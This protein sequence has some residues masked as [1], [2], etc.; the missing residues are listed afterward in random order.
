MWANCLGCKG[1][2]SFF[3]L[4]LL[5]NSCNVTRLLEDDEILYDKVEIDFESKQDVKKSSQL[6]E[7]LKGVGK[8]SPNNKW[9]GV[10]RFNLWAYFNGDESKGGISS[11]LARQGEEPV[12][13]DSILVQTNCERMNKY[14][15]NQGYYYSEVEY[16]TKI[17][18]KKAKVTYVANLGKQYRID[19][20]FYSPV[21]SAEIDLIVEINKSRSFIK[22]GLAFNTDLF[23]EERARISNKMKQNGYF[24]FDEKYVTFRVDSSGNDQKISVFVDIAKPTDGEHEKYIMDDIYVIN[25]F[26]ASL[27]GQKVDTISQNDFIYISDGK[28]F[29]PIT[30]LDKIALKKGAYY[31][32]FDHQLSFRNLL[33]MGVFKFVNIRFEEHKDSLDRNLLTCFIYLTPLKKMKISIETEVNNKFTDTPASNSSLGTALTGTYMNRNLFRGSELFTI[34]LY[35]GLE[36][37]IFNDA[38]NELPI[39]NNINISGTAKL[40]IPKLMVPFPKRWLRSTWQQAAKQ[41]KVKSTFAFTE[42]FRR[43]VNFY[44]LNITEFSFGYDWKSENRARHILTPASFVYSFIYNQEEEF[45]KYLDDDLRIQKSF[46]DK[47]IIGGSYSYI[48]TNN[49]ISN[50]AYQSRYKRKSYFFKGDIDLTGNVMSL[51]EKALIGTNLIKD[52]FSTAFGGLDYSQFLRLQADYRQYWTRGNES[53]VGRVYGGIGIPYGNSTVLPFIRQFFSGGSTGLRAFRARG[54]GPGYY[55]PE[56]PDR[57]VE[58]IDTTLNNINFYRTGDIKLEANLEYRFPIYWFLKG[59]FFVD[60]GNVW[61]IRDDSLKIGEQFT[62][63]SFWN[64][65]GIGAGFGLRFDFSFF[66]LR[67]DLATPLYVPFYDPGNRWTL[68]KFSGANWQDQA[69][70]RK[71]LIFQLGIGYPF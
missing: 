25:D 35:A 63:K 43:W 19:S 70:R 68:D 64:E 4:S 6:K 50:K 37:N 65:I 55:D 67:F 24:A 33:D 3:I 17:R 8:P 32:S 61:T 46:E 39:I 20:V 10:F 11:W 71:N 49:R 29:K 69:W 47:L 9:L 7:S 23:Q 21:D 18:G 26:N 14:L 56:N 53:L 16:K 66:V 31:S 59:A 58:S 62:L 60:A 34:N 1:L 51:L 45:L 30:I 52:D 54:I 2:I 5:L 38:D 42:E 41:N 22:S 13:L 44:S 27:D 40:A 36:F 15:F 28:E 48:N 57:N 12:L